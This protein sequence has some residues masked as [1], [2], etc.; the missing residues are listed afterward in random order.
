M[1]YNRVIRMESTFEGLYDEVVKCLPDVLKVVRKES[2][3]RFFH[4]IPKI[5]AGTTELLCAT[6]STDGVPVLPTGT[7]KTRSNEVNPSPL[8]PLRIHGVIQARKQR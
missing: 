4:E 5:V 8:D 3:E 2:P 6:L 1:S 7:G